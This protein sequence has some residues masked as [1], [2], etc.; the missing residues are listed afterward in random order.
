MGRGLRQLS[1]QPPIRADMAFRI[2]MDRIRSRTDPTN[3]YFRDFAS[4]FLKASFASSHLREPA[5]ATAH[6][7]PPANA[8]DA[9]VR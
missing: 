1:L 6:A 4:T 5:S 7:F 2:E 9:S 3:R 8:P